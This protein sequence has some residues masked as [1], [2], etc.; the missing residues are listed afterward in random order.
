MPFTTIE[1][2]GCLSARLWQEWREESK[3]FASARETMMLNVLI[4]QVFERIMPRP[5]TIPRKRQGSELDS[6]RIQRVPIA[7]YA[8][9]DKRSACRARQGQVRRDDFHEDIVVFEYGLDSH[10]GIRV[11]QVPS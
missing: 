10:G 2:H 6:E 3:N 5:P 4:E 11:L 1:L 7:A 9:A 8:S